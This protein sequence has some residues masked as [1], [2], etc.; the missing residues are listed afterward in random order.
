MTKI[1]SRCWE[2]KKSQIEY[3]TAKINIFTLELRQRLVQGCWEHK[4]TLI[5]YDTSKI[6]IF[7]LELKPI[8]IGTYNIG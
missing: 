7:T 3:D 1:G 5:E 6:N 2:N 4:K 8:N